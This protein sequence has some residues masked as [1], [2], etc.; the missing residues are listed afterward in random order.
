MSK[1]IEGLNDG[2]KKAVQHTKGPLRLLA[3]AGS[4]KTRVLTHKI[5]YL[6]EEKGIRP[7]KIL[8]V[9]FTNKAAGEMKE[10]VAAII[11]EDKAKKSLLSTYHSMCVRILRQDIQVLGYP[12]NFNI[13]DTIDQRQVLK[14]IYKKYNISSKTMPY[15]HMLD[16]ISKAKSALEEPEELI[17]LAETE[18]DKYKALIYKGYRD[19]T[20][21]S[22]SLDFDDLLIFVY[23][24]F[25]DHE[26][27][28][29]K[30]KDKFDYVLV[31][32]FQDTSWIQYE[33]VKT[34]AHHNNITIVGDPDQTIYTWRGAKVELII[35]FDKDFKESTTIKLEENYRSTQEILKAAN[36]LIEHN[37][38]RLPKKLI[39]NSG[40]GEK[41]TFHH[42]YSPEAEAK[43][44][45]QKID[46][47]RRQKIQLKDMTIFY[48][49]NYLSRTMEQALINGNI[50][51]KIFGDVKFFERKEIKDALAYLKVIAHADEVGLQ[52]IINVP[53]RKIGSTTIEK[54]ANFSEEK[55]LPLYETITKFYGVL[56]V[57][58]SQRNSLGT[59]F[60]LFGKY[61]AALKTNSIKLVLEKFLIEIGY[62]T[63]LNQ[64][65]ETE[66][67]ANVKEL[68][69]TIG[70][71]EEENPNKTI[72]DYLEQ[73]AL[74][75]AQDE[76][77]AGSSYINLMTI[78]T[79][80]G[81]EFDNV[82]I[83]GMSEQV[84][85]S[86]KAI[87]AGLDSIEEERRLAY[88]AVTRARQRLFISDSKGYS[89]D[90]R[91]MKVPSR[92]ISEMGIRI[93][94]F[95]REIFI[96]KT[97]DLHY[98]KVEDVEFKIGSKVKHKVFG[99]GEIKELDGEMAVIMFEDPYGEKTLMKNHKSLS[100]VEEIKVETEE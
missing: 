41:I 14:P 69:D 21:K 76:L 84:F 68:I 36:S 61:R 60:N 42:A 73:I 97:M 87:D 5:A 30:W 15:S 43:W 57:S 2:Q 91:F 4:G 58:T 8:A 16:Y 67:V 18:G 89:I 88:V 94:D 9:T 74:M 12:R 71:W 56:P 35:N 70:K 85:P 95:T 54:L 10:R 19:Q 7:E 11:G 92:F 90:H 20:I 50:P 66:K 34:L 27:V 6:V 78:H 1:I 3:G 47:L 26:S 53:A 22:K 32:E 72:D 46:E 83:I 38:K 86:S 55:K 99:I 62:M 65:K 17:S 49:S 64:F 40:E 39:S 44:V 23:K 93:K 79:S 100:S 51:Y 25:K 82:F 52:R 45:V 48:R 59:S 13:I 98:S 63:T 31:D 81:L 80:K 77:G 37:K 28:A 33:I 96:P 75:S 24:L 29:N